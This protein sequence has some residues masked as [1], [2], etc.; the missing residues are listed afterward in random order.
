MVAFVPTASEARAA[1]EAVGHAQVARAIERVDAEERRARRGRDPALLGFRVLV[2][3]EVRDALQRD[4]GAI[5][6][7]ADLRRAIER[8]ALAIQVSGGPRRAGVGLDGVAR[9][10]LPLAREPRRAEEV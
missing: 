3:R 5:D 9:M 1:R 4:S 2:R 10:R 6:R 7:R 8:A